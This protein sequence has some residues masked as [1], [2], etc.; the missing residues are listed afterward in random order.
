MERLYWERYFPLGCGSKLET[1]RTKHHLKLSVVHR[2]F[3]DM[4][5]KLSYVVDQHWLVVTGCHFWN[6]PIQLG[7]SSS[8]L[9]F[10][11]FFQRGRPQPP[12]TGSRLSSGDPA[13]ALLEKAAVGPHPNP[14]DPSELVACASSL[15]LGWLVSSWFFMCIVTAAHYPYKTTRC[16]VRAETK[17][18]ISSMHLT[19]EWW[20]SWISND[21]NR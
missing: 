10:L 17:S 19:G 9:T 11:I 12:T 7:I 16:F 8:Q 6:F 15:D 1:C 3:F 14:T 18:G 21:I 20:L 4:L 2:R 5:R 13:M